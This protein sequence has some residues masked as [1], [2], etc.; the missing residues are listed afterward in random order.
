MPTTEYQPLV[1]AVAAHS[2]GVIE[3]RTRTQQIKVTSNLD[4]VNEILRHCDGRGAVGLIV[5]QVARKM[6][7]TSELIRAVI[8]DLHTMEIL[9]DSR[10]YAKHAHLTGN[11]PMAFSHLIGDDE[12]ERIYNNRPSYLVAHATP[13]EEVVSP[14]S[15]LRDLLKKRASTRNFTEA[16]LSF[17]DY[18]SVCEMA[19]G[20]DLS[21]VPSAGALYPLSIFLLVVR[22]NETM[23]S[24]VYQYDPLANVLTVVETPLDARYAE[25][26]LNNDTLLHGA[27]GVFVICGDLDRHSSKYANRGLRY[28]LI[29]SGHVAQN[30]HLAAI[31]RHYA[32]LEYGGF[33][34]EPLRTLLHLEA[35]SVWP[36]VTVAIGVASTDEDDLDSGYASTRKELESALVG[37]SKPLNW[38][39]PLYKEIGANAPFNIASAHYK[40][41]TFENARKTYGSRIS[42]G[43]S[44]SQDLA[45]I[46]AMAEGFER[47]SFARPYVDLVSSAEDLDA[48]WVDPNVYTPFA[49]WQ[50]KQQGLE[51][52]DPSHEWQWVNGEDS[53]GQRVYV[54]VDLVFYP[55]DPL[56]YGR[57]LCYSAHSNGCAA[58]TSLEEAK[59]NAVHELIE[60]D[61]IIRNWLMKT[62][63][64]RVP[65]EMLPL[66]WQK[67]VVFW[68]NQGWEVD[69]VD[70]SHSGVAVVSVF[71]RK[72]RARPYLAHGSAASSISFELAIDKAFQEL[73]VALAI[74]MD[75]RYA[76]IMPEKVES[77]ADHGR[78]YHFDDYAHE[79]DYLFGGDFIEAKP[80]VGGKD[81]IEQFDPIYVEVSP[82]G[83]PLKVVRALSSKLVPV[84]FGYARD[85]ISHSAVKEGVD[86]SAS[87]FPHYL[88]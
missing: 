78:V 13:L 74:E 18:A 55:Y 60:R 12:V 22:G 27:S 65:L 76:R 35:E 15:A 72:R 16:T 63:P 24:G 6:S 68:R 75:Q 81:V 77:P 32:T 56:G 86:Q 31:E 33:N 51:R 38:V 3:F 79:L 84:N 59:V 11:N 46:K 8:Q 25:F 9:I 53:N 80:V 66:Q 83:S 73:E 69:V 28:T 34:E 36:L 40:P 45:A 30:V 58:H 1:V 14:P 19:Y 62:T 57:E 48:R 20:F 37:R 82:D 49:D 52:F 43:T 42:A 50:L 26:A 41:G 85:H 5:R 29:E 87:P 61:A 47:Y 4:L 67:R 23:A 2:D 39:V 17:E 44:V 21:P 70:F 71:A 64:G 7:V 54:P 88:A 10:E